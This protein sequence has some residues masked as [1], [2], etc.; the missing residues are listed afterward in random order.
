LE[1]NATFVKVIKPLKLGMSN[2][3]IMNITTYY[4]RSIVHMST[5][6]NMATMPNFM[7]YLLQLTKRRHMLL[8]ELYT[9]PSIMQT[10][11]YD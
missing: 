5:I 7:L 2:K 10:L 1:K 8:T 6:T 3:H 11:M 4:A 9:T